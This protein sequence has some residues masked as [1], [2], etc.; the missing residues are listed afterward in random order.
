VRLN[1]EADSINAAVLAPDVDSESDSYGLFL[2]N[3]AVDMTQ[4]A[5][6]KCTAVR[7]I[8]VPADR[9]EEVRADLVAELGRFPLG[10]PAEKGVRVGP[11]TDERQ[12]KDVRAGIERLSAHAEVAC[13]GA[14]PVGD[15]GC[16]VQPT[17]L[18][19]RDAREGAFHDAEVF[20][21]VATILPYSGTAEEAVELTN[22]G[23]GGLVCSVYS[24]SNEWTR[25]FV[26]G[27]A[28]WHGRVWIGSDRVAEQALAPGMVLPGSVHG[29]PGRAGGGE[30]LGALRGL[31]LY[32]QRTA[33]QGFK[34]LLEGQFG[35][36][37]LEE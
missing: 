37:V 24:N 28:P 35:A 3:V 32:L 27:V 6:Q 20:G 4:K 2:R 16:F 26:L 8:L 14:E 11:V 15:A 19:A 22:L 23:G 31:D 18:V 12:L 5:G 36:P 9:V 17:L 25:E 10:D 21:P 7:R 34:G 33:L 30:E 13:G 29:G 1:L